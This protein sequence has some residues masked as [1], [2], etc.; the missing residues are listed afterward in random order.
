MP[1]VIIHC[2]MMLSWAAPA[3]GRELGDIG[4]GDRG[5]RSDRQPDECPGREQHGGIDGDR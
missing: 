1:T 5:V 4:G 2:W 3:A